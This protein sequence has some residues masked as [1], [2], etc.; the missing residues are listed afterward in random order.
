MPEVG[1][2]AEEYTWAEIKAISEAGKAEEYFA[3][4][5]TKTFILK[6]NANSVVT[7][8]IIAFDA[9]TKADGKGTA[10]I[11]WLIKSVTNLRHPMNS[12]N[13]NA[14]GW[15]ESKLREWLQNDCTDLFPEDVLSVITVVEKSYYDRTSQSTKSCDDTLW[16]PSYR[17]MFGNSTG[18]TNYETYGTDYT[19]FFTSNNARRKY[20]NYWTRTPVFSYENKFW[21][22][23]ANGVKNYSTFANADG[24]VVF[25][26]C[27]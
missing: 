4:G 12:D 6:D 18:D 3:L 9:D 19:E 5:D 24:Y 14:G 10:G 13:T 1:K 20:S 8:Q 11:T 7:M 25:G 23:D 15:E 22:V 17:E 27:T 16:I 26:F 2:S 21:D